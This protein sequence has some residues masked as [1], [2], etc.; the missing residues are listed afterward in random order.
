VHQI[1]IEVG[2]IQVAESLVERFLHGDG[3]VTCD[4]RPLLAIDDKPVE[5]FCGRP[6]RIPRRADI[7]IIPQLACHPNILPSDSCVL[8]AEGDA[9]AHVDFIAICCCAVNVP[10]PRLDGMKYCVGGIVT[11]TLQI[12]SSKAKMRNLQWWFWPRWGDGLLVIAKHA[13]PFGNK[14]ESRKEELEEP[15]VERWGSVHAVGLKIG[16]CCWLSVSDRTEGQRA[17]TATLACLAM[18]PYEMGWAQDSVS[19]ADGYPSHPRA[20]VNRLK[21]RGTLG[22]VHSH[23]LN[24]LS[25]NSYYGEA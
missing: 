14:R 8:Q 24:S 15:H 16:G 2:Q 18:Q 20:T 21:A 7:R 11:I 3:I 10:I 6:H 1:Q 23:A 22:M 19:M 12:P 13:V 9:S 25:A 17:L 4:K 5:T